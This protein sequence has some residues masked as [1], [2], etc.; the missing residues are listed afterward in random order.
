MTIQQI[1]NAIIPR[2]GRPS[3][4]FGTKDRYNAIVSFEYRPTE[5]LHFFLDSLY[6]KKKPISSAST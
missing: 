1:D 5:N 3:D 4:E 6:G 2:L